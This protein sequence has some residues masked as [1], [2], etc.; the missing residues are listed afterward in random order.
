MNFQNETVLITGASNGIGMHLSKAYAKEGASVIMIDH[1]KGNG[2]KLQNELQQEEHT[3][4]FYHCELSNPEQITSTLKDIHERH[5][6][7]SIL[8]NNAGLSRFQDFFELTVE[9]WDNVLNSNLR[10]IFLCSQF[11]ASKWKEEGIHG[12]IV[13]MAST[14]ALMSESNSEAYAAS[15][16]GIVALTH[17]LAVTLSDYQIRVNAISPGWIQ[18]ENY[19][20]LRD[21]D[22]SQHLSKR[23]GHPSDI[24]RACLY[25]TDKENAF[26]TGENLVVDGGMTRKMIYEH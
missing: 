7:P 16:G 10:S 11:I 25:L 1:D 18:T 14:R 5:G 19:D 6:T 3:A 2:E 26:V 24:A 9:E 12:R 13:N 17:A 21:I 22:H 8:I 15:K 4:H 20:K 23:V